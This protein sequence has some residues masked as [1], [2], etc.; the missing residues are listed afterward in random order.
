VVVLVV[1]GGRGGSVGSGSGRGGSRG[2]S[3][4]GG[5]GGVS[6]NE[7]AQREDRGLSDKQSPIP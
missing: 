5:S 7:L 4:R 2:G 3:G 6:S 1:V